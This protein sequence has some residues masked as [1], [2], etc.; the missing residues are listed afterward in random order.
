MLSD[1]ELE[2]QEYYNLCEDDGSGAIIQF[3]GVVRNNT[4]S[5]KPVKGLF[6]EAHIELAEQ[7]IQQIILETIEKFHLQKAHCAH[8]IGEL[9]VGEK[10]IIVTVAGAHR[11]ES[12][13][14]CNYLVNRV[15]YE[16]PIWKKELFE[17]GTSEWGRNSGKKPDYIKD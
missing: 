4:N 3:I 15:K 9:Q 16:A 17:D 7:V 8:R 2:A 10:A 14:A 12:F 13:E 11:E 6:Y 5:P 1:K